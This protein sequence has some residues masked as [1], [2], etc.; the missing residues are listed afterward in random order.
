MKKFLINF[1]FLIIVLFFNDGI[2]IFIGIFLLNVFNSVDVGF[3]VV[4]YIINIL[5]FFFFVV[6]FSFLN[7]FLFIKVN[8]IF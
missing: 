4:V 5:D 8:N 7:V 1:I 6:F 2:F 3:F